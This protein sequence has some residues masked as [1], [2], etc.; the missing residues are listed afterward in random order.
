MSIKYILV[1]TTCV[2]LQSALYTMHQDSDSDLYAIDISIDNQ[3]GTNH[4]NNQLL[5]NNQHTTNHNPLSK[6]STLLSLVNQLKT[7]LSE[8]RS[9]INKNIIISS[10]FFG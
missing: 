5:V 10:I 7:S 9:K 8:Q 4:E 2:T 1:F 6:K 3:N